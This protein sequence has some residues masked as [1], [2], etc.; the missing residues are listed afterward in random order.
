MKIT[1]DNKISVIDTLLRFSAYLSKDSSANNLVYHNRVKEPEKNNKYHFKLGDGITNIIYKGREIE[2]NY[3]I[4]KKIVGNSV[5]A[6]KYHLLTLT[7]KDANIKLFEEFLEDAHNYCK[8]KKEK[9]EVLTFIFKTGYWNNLS[10]LPKR[11]KSTLHLPNKVLPNLIKDLRDFLKGEDKYLK[12]GIPYKRNYLLEGL[13]GTGKTSLIFVLASYFNMDIAIINFSLSIDDATF[14]KSVTKLPEDCFLVL[15]D[16]DT[17]FVERKPGDSNRSMVSFSGIL[18]TL[19]GIARRTKQ[20]TFLTTNYISKLDS[21]LIRPGRIDKVITFNYSTSEQIKYFFDSF[22]PNQKENW[23]EFVKKIKNIKTTSAIL[24]SFFFKYINSDNILVHVD[25]L[26][27][28]SHDKKAAM[29][30]QMYL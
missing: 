12:Y 29:I 22:L 2:I 23:D 18:N 16:I 24:Q 27:K 30:D 9:E 5:Q 10:R 17:L 8:V 6:V 1:I 26:K 21:A 13:P 25:E 4:S 15:E 20:I 28:M 14:M 19:D 7:S 3:M 11:D